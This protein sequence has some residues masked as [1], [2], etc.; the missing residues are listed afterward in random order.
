M[1]FALNFF[2]F[3]LLESGLRNFGLTGRKQQDL[4][5]SCDPLLTQVGEALPSSVFPKESFR[6]SAT[7]M[8]DF[9]GVGRGMEWVGGS[10]ED[11]KRGWFFQSPKQSG[12]MCI[13]L[14][15]VFFSKWGKKHKD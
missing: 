3:Q 13:F 15:Y 5:L 8:M 9:W 7:E 11:S 14:C 4:L 12:C 10:P 1:E 2:S 6:F